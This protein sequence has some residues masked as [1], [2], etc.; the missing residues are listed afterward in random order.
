MRILHLLITTCVFT[1]LTSSSAVA[2]HSFS[3]TFSEEVISVEGSVERMNFK[4]P[5]VI[6][7]FNVTDENGE[8]TE[9]MSEGGAATL[10]RR[11]GWDRDTLS[12][13]DYIRIT[14]NAT[15]NGSPMV[16]MEEVHFI[17]P[18]SG[19]VLSSPGT[20][21]RAPYDHAAT[22]LNLDDG[23]PNFSGYWASSR[24]RVGDVTIRPTRAQPTFNEAGAAVQAA[25]D[26]KD[27][28]QVQCEP[29]G[30]VRQV[31]TPH[32]MRI[33]QFEDRV[34]FSY[35]EYGG[36]RTIYFDDR[37]L[38]GG[39][40]SNFGQSSARYEDEKLIIESTH[41][42]GNVTSGRGQALSDQ[43]TSIET[44]TRLPEENGISG[45][46]ISITM[47]DPTYLAET[48]TID[49]QKYFTPGHEFIEVDCHKPLAY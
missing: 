26:I 8:I 23:K 5:H 20:G 14:G 43:Y 3:S 4:N 49:L 47:T 24:R 40:H 6:V 33:Q 35:E 44:Y 48:W 11:E 46:N 19:A 22:S 28:P 15:H 45:I 2:H 37:A 31:I 17:D 32:P 21:E 39:E 10:K 13:G 25:Y 12:K 41:L 27:D 34:E 30:L 1:G 42:V 7:Y 29:P 18:A 9:W 38:V 16:S 36:E